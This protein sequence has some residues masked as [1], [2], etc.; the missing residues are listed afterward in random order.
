MIREWLPQPLDPAMRRAVER[1]GASEGVVHVALMPD[2]HLAEH[3]V[4][5]R[6]Q[7]NADGAALVAA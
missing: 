7:V 6:A 5:D 3:V 1:L 4:Q 2:A